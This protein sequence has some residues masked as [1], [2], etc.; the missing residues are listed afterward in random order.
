MPGHFV[1]VF[2]K[3]YQ[4]H[5]YRVTSC[6]VDVYVTTKSAAYLGLYVKNV[7]WGSLWCFQGFYCT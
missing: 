2:V 3:S 1:L 6:I 4:E 5:W 7:S